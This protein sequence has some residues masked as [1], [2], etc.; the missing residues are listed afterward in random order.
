MGCPFKRAWRGGGDD[1]WEAPRGDEESGGAWGPAR[2]S[3]DAVWPA[4][5]H[6]GSACAGGARPVPKQGRRG[7]ARWGPGTVTGGRI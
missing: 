3:S 7:T 1:R 6:A 2:Q 4:A 5:V